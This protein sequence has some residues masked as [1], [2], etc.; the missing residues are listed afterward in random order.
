LTNSELRLVASPSNLTCGMQ[1][2]IEDYD[3]YQQGRGLS[4][5]TRRRRR[6]SLTGFAAELEHDG[7]DFAT[8]G[9]LDVERYIGCRGKPAT[10]R[11]VLIDLR[12]FYRWAC[13]RELLPADPTVLAEAPRVPRPLPRPL[14]AFELTLAIRAAT[15][16]LRAMVML[17]SHAGLRVSEIAALR[18]GDVDRARGVI[19]VVDGKGGKD[20]IVPLHPDLADVLG[21]LPRRR[22]GFVIGTTGQNVS[23][24]IRDH[25]AHLEIEHKPH[26]LR[27][28]FGTEISMLSNGNMPLVAGLLGHESME[29]SRHYNAYNPAGRS[30]VARLYE[31]AA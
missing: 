2:L 5:E 24:R 25:F 14:S 23:H 11:A 29:T 13:A 19:R 10:R 27:A 1:T 18:P 16:R 7:R 17:G 15:P 22:D 12:C 6:W 31:R 20:R 4:P 21:R 8:A 9:L 3:R 30:I 28:T 26:D